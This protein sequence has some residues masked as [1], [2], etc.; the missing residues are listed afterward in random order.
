MPAKLEEQGLLSLFDSIP[1]KDKALI[2]KNYPM[3]SKQY[4]IQGDKATWDA[5][6]EDYN[7]WGHEGDKWAED[8]A[9][10]YKGKI[11]PKDFLGLTLEESSFKKLM[12]DGIDEFKPLD[13][14]KFNKERH[15]PIF[16]WIDIVGTV[17]LYGGLMATANV[18]GHEGRHRCFGLMKL[19]VKSVDIE[20]R[21]REGDYFDKYNPTA[22]SKIILFGQFNKDYTAKINNPIPMSWR[23]HK[24]IRPELKDECLHESKDFRL[25]DYQRRLVREF[26]FDKYHVETVNVGDIVKS[27]KLLDDKSI[28]DRRAGTWGKTFSDFHFSN[29]KASYDTPI[30]LSADH[31]VLDGHH[32]LIALYNDGF[33]SAEVF[34]KN[35]S[36][37]DFCYSD[38]E[39]ALNEKIVKKGSKWQVQSEKGRNM[40]T[41]DTK[42][43]AEKRLQQVHYFKYM[44][45]DKEDYQKKFDE[46]THAHIDRVNKYAKKINKEYPHHDEDKFNELYDGYSLMSKNKEDITKEEQAMIDDATFKHVINNEHHCEHWVDHEDI[47]GFSRDNPT[48]HGCLDCSKMPESAL[49]EMCCDWCAMSEEFGNTPFEWYEKN[50]DTRWHFNEEQDKYILDTLHKLWDESLK[51]TMT[52]DEIRD[53]LSAFWALGFSYDK[54][55]DEKAQELVRQY[56]ELQ[57]KK[58]PG[59]EIMKK[60]EADNYGIDKDLYVAETKDLCLAKSYGYSDEEV[61][62]NE[63]YDHLKDYLLAG[64]NS[65]TYF[66]MDDFSKEE[67]QYIQ[68]NA[69]KTKRPL[70]RFENSFRLSKV[71][72]IVNMY[73]MRSFTA[74]KSGVNY[75]ARTFDFDDEHENTLYKTQGSTLYYD[76]RWLTQDD[77]DLGGEDE[78]FVWG[79]FKVVDISEITIN[80][81]V[82]KLVTIEQI[83]TNLKENYFK[84]MDEDY[85]EDDKLVVYRVGQ[86]DDFKQGLFFAD[87]LDY[88]DYSDTGYEKED[89]E[90]Y[91]LDLKN[92]KVFDPM[93]EWNLSVNTWSD[94]RQSEEFFKEHDYPYYEYLDGVDYDDINEYHEV[95]TD[96]DYLAQYAYEEGYDVCILRDIPG[97]GGRGPNQTE[98]CVFNKNLIKKVEEESLKE[99]AE[100]RDIYYRGYD[101]RYGILD[102]NTSIL[103]TWVTDSIEYAQEY[104]EK[105]EFGKIA[106]VRITCKDKE[107]GGVFDLPED[108][109]YYEPGDEEFKEYI[110]DQGLK[111]YGFTAGDYDDFC[112]CIS[113]DC[114]EVIDPDVKVEVENESLNEEVNKYYRLEL[115]DCWRNRLGL[116]T[117]AFEAIPSKETIEN[118]PEDFEDLTQEER[119]RYYRFDELLNKLS[120]IKSPGIDAK[121]QNFK[122]DDIFAFTSSKYNE[123]LPIIKEMRQLLKEMGFKLI[124][125]ELDIDD[126]NISYRDDDQ[127]AFS[128]SNSSKYI[129]ESKQD[130]EKLTESLKQIEQTGILISDSLYEI[131]NKILNSKR[132]LKLVGVTVNGEETWLIGNPYG[133]THDDMLAYAEDCGYLSGKYEKKNNVYLNTVPYN[134]QINVFVDYSEGMEYDYDNTRIVDVTARHNYDNTNSFENTKLFKILGEPKESKPYRYS[135]HMKTRWESLNET[136]SKQED[137][138][139]NSVV[140]DRDGNLL[141]VYHCSFS[142]F[143][144]FSIDQEDGALDTTDWRGE[145]G[146]AWFADNIDYARNYGDDSFEYECYLNIVNPLDIGE[147]NAEVEDEYGTEVKD[148]YYDEGVISVSS[149][150][151][152]LCKLVKT[153]PEVMIKWYHKWYDTGYI[154]DLTRRAFFKNLV[155]KLGY[156]GVMATESGERTWGCVR[157]NQIK[158]IDNENPTEKDSMKESKQEVTFDKKSYKPI[159]IGGEEYSENDVA[160]DNYYGVLLNGEHIGNV[161]INDNEIKGFEIYSK[162][163]KKGLGKLVIKELLKKHPDINFVESIPEAKKF[164]EKV[165]FSVDYYDDDSGLYC[166]SLSESKQR[167]DILGKALDANCSDWSYNDESP[168]IDLSKPLV[169]EDLNKPS[170]LFTFT[171]KDIEEKYPDLISNEYKSCGPAFIMPD[172]RFILTRNRFDTH[173]DFAVQCMLDIAKV[174][175]DEFD[176]D[177]ILE[178]FTKHFGLIRVNDG[179]EKDIEPRAYFVIKDRF[180]SSQQWES[181]RDFLEYLIKNRFANKTYDIQAF[182]GDAHHLWDLRNPSEIPNP[183]DMIEECRFAIRRGFFESLDASN[184]KSAS[185]HEGYTYNELDGTGNY[186]VNGYT[187]KMPDG[188]K[189]QIR[190]KWFKVAKNELAC[191]IFDAVT[192]AGFDCAID[193]PRYSLYYRDKLK[194]KE[195]EIKLEGFDFYV[196]GPGIGDFHCR[197]VEPGYFQF[198]EVFIKENAQK[199]GIAGKIIG[200]LLGCLDSSWRVEVHANINNEFWSHIMKKYPQFTWMG[201]TSESLNKK[202]IEHSE[203]DDILLSEGSNMT[204]QE[205]RE[206]LK[207]MTSMSE[208]ELAEAEAFYKAESKRLEESLGSDSKDARRAKRLS[209]WAHR[210]LCNKYHPEAYTANME[211]G[212]DGKSRIIEWVD[213]LEIQSSK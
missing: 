109:D 201:V 90:M 168:R 151:I 157:P 23:Q 40:G 113:K 66:G 60:S 100:D 51:E 133:D 25:S 18:T 111:G 169:R 57:K 209:S 29:E 77:E 179:T 95:M 84:H 177:E 26:P 94:I 58:L 123:I 3:P 97:D 30:R 74:T 93:K 211:E 130:I 32:R 117:G 154:Y 125:K 140:R 107:I 167:A 114:V 104:A 19:G 163:R 106:K 204:A 191:K 34:V 99:E 96:T 75:I 5:D 134:K 115:E 91:E 207:S 208:K 98:Y 22:F 198:R 120:K 160:C 126:A 24:A 193:G 192:K 118:Y 182:F 49:E 61:F 83:D 35:E 121:L 82:F 128:K 47:E 181:L 36:L 45:E 52:D 17:Q 41:Y 63:F 70:Y 116:F 175:Y 183:E 21:V 68:K 144:T 131:K 20:I 185:I 200:I 7:F 136:T 11:D 33:N 46:R 89:A 178:Q 145:F 210:C 2:E 159:V 129:N 174:R 62:E 202:P 65:G 172:G 73:P 108:V 56:R 14:D 153:E 166:M 173:E 180:V 72:D 142:E 48:P 176:I 206:T 103:Y 212:H 28:L 164:W 27:N 165:G 147:L 112:M 127:V 110:L 143:D 171:L 203:K 170:D 146:F 55:H 43:E 162:F 54:Y 119:D 156:D 155:V 15:Q 81:R 67:L 184:E 87:S 53:N 80:K 195:K 213:C 138:F 42:A 71:G 148:D 88:F 102:S 76:I 190:G 59:T 152:R 10:A 189:K 150:F 38:K 197:V 39:D 194:T 149:D 69:K 4:S 137:F 158:L 187:D 139:K 6:A 188:S 105:D 64:M 199:Q 186:W 132:A 85:F 124:V 1:M 13:I 205:Y 78:V 31:K 135:D 50:K 16:L 86:V 122:E 79:R 101:S 141:P 12:S 92:A 196:D 161:A 9:T 8:Y 37:N 44:N